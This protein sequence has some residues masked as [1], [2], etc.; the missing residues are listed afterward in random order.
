MVIH[1]LPD[2]H[3]RYIC[4][5]TVDCTDLVFLRCNRS[6]FHA[7]GSM[8]P[9]SSNSGRT[10][11]STSTVVSGTPPNRSDVYGSSGYAIVVA[12]FDWW[13][14]SLERTYIYGVWNCG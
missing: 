9:S 13:R 12:E 11:I 7:V 4:R 5:S 10:P 2:V 3:G 8:A 14:C 6:R 1:G